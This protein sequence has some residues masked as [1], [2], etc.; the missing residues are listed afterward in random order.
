MNKIKEKEHSTSFVVMPKHLN[1]MGIIFGG[2]FMSELDLAAAVIVNKAVRESVTADKAV[3][4]KFNVEFIK[5]SF[6]GDIIY[7]KAQIKETR[8]KAISVKLGA[9]REGRKEIGKHK[10]ASGEA[11]FVTMNE[12]HYIN[13]EL[14]L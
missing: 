7:I 3:T 5:P 4:F 14:E 1:Y 6:E 11:V 8:K 12:N 13:H 9:W 10:V 2:V